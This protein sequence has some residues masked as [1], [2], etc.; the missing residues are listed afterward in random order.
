VN[1]DRDADASRLA[2]QALTRDD[3]TG[4][5]ERLY[6]KAATGDAIVPW[7][8]EEPHPLL[9]SWLD[10]H[11]SDGKRA[12][13]VGC[14]FGRDAEHIASCGYLTTAFDISP[15]AVRLTRERFPE[16]SVDYTVAD[17]LAPPAEWTGAFD[18]VVESIT[19]QSMPLSVRADA[20][21][22][23]ARLVAPGGELLVISGMRGEHEQVDGPPW[24]LT[25]VEVES[26]ATGGLRVVRIE[27]PKAQMWRAVFQRPAQ[28]HPR[29][30]AAR[31]S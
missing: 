30:R 23:V 14:G 27:V 29:S 5:F 12:M 4:W 10:E 19:V 24:P 1:S 6:A 17:L 22:N 13:V 15:T 16:S 8:R 9:V 25:R 11:E 28:V 26:F 21:G 31:P 20:I 2:A 7:D 3:P 18:L